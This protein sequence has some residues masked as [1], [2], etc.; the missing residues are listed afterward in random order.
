MTKKIVV[1]R[2]ENSYGMGPFVGGFSWKILV[3]ID[4]ELYNKW[5]SMSRKMPGP[6]EDGMNDFSLEFVF[7]CRSKKQLQSWFKMFLDLLLENGYKIRSYSVPKDSVIFGKNQ[8]VFRK[9]DAVLKEEV[10][11]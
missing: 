1:Y 2:I 10:T 8:I 3:K 5:V 6:F 11:K 7:G 4:K 9:K